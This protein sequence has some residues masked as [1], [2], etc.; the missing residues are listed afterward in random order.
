MTTKVGDRWK[1]SLFTLQQLIMDQA[2]PRL[3]VL[4]L[5]TFTLKPPPLTASLQSCRE[6]RMKEAPLAHYCA[7]LCNDWSS[8]GL[9]AG[10]AWQAHKNSDY[11][12]VVTVVVVVVVVLALLRPTAHCLQCRCWWTE[13]V[14]W[15]EML[16]KSQR[17]DS[18]AA[19]GGWRVTSGGT[20]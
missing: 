11:S 2:F 12:E 4:I 19:R 16:Q 1:S 9:Q 20:G 3:I 10:I 5:M 6:A 18:E 8:A 13:W 17:S 15:M 14:C 7:C